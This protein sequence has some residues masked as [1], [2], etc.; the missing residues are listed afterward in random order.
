MRTIK[1]TIEYD[2]THFYGWQIQEK[3]KR[4]VQGEFYKAF[5]KVFK[6]QPCLIGSGR[7][8]SG[9]HALGQVA[10]F[11]TNSKLP[12]QK[13]I[14][15][16]NANLPS[17]IA[18]VDAREVNKNFHAQFSAKSKIYRYTI[19]NR[20]ARPALKRQLCYFYPFPL[21][22]K[23]M[24][25][26]AKALVGKHDFSSFRA[27]D[28]ARQEKDSVRTIK[29]LAISKQG[30]TITIDI[31]ANGFLYK[32]VRNIVGTLLEIGSDWL[33]KGSIKKILAKKSRTAAG[34]T[35]ATK[36]LTLIKVKYN[37]D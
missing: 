15:A 6:A 14:S 33:P 29:K 36:G 2:G 3:S 20:S 11:K 24:Q 30:D 28:P 35:A 18:V 12:V 5:Q 27:S 1:L 31:E 9:V 16:L 22:I 25:T 21:N 26:E 37:H 7:T 32:M 10:H 19:L 13:I 34:K 23:L 17:D 4:T 8:D